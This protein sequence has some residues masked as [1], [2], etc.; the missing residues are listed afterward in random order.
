MAPVVRFL[1]LLPFLF[2]LTTVQAQRPKTPVAKAPVMQKYKPPKLTSTLGI[3]SDSASVFVEEAVQL[4]KL[5]LKITDDKKNSY[6]ISSY[7]V[8]YKRKA[9]TEN[10]ETGKVTPIMSN[11]ADLFRETPLPE[12]WKRILTEQLRPGEE[13]F[14]FDIIAKD[15]QGRLMFAPDLKI[16][17]K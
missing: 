8:M 3:R 11:V 15:A 9:V 17:I 12:L 14:F 16:K 10:E 5:P 7:Q 4:V 6:S 1:L 2:I 13:I